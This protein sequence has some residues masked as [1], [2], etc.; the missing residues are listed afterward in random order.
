MVSVESRVRKIEKNP[1]P[2]RLKTNVVTTDKLAFRAVTTKT[3]AQ[4][5]ITPNEA[6][7]GTTV[8]TA[9]QPTTN[10]K[11]GTTWVNPDDGSTNVYSTATE[12]F[13]TVTDPAAVAI[14]QGKN[15]TYAQD[16]EPTGGTYS[17][18][19]LWIDTN[20]GN[21][22]YAYN[23][24]A[25]A[26]RQDGAIS[27][28]Q[29]TAN[30]KNTITY[31]TSDPGATPNTAGDIWWKYAADIIIGQWTGLGGTTWR[32][33][34]IG[35]ALVANLDAGK[36]TT[37]YLDVAGTV[38]I[39]TSSTASGLGGSAARI[40][41]NST[42]FYAYDGTV[43][44]VSITNTGTA[45]FSGTV[46][47]SGGS[48]TGYVTAG[49]TRIG[50]EVQAGKNGMYINTNNY[51]YDDATFKVGDGTESMS[52][53]SAGGLAVTGEINATSGA[54]S[55][56]V[57][58]GNM[59]IGS[60]VNSSYEGIYIG[61]NNYWYDD[62]TFKVGD[63][64]ESLVWNSSNGLT[65]TG[66]VNANSGVFSGSIT[67]I[68]T[69]TGGTI[70][71]ATIEAING[72]NTLAIYPSYN[73]STYGGGGVASVSSAAIVN[74]AVSGVFSG[75]KA[76]YVADTDA[77]GGI[78]SYSLNV[79]I[80][81][82]FASTGGG[83]QASI[84]SFSNLITTTIYGDQITLSSAYN[85]LFMNSSGVSLFDSTAVGNFGL[86]NVKGVSSSSGFTAATDTSGAVGDVVLVYTP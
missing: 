5:A 10:L 20:D 79:G 54:F 33:N 7:F 78:S 37:G 72:G 2:K 28:A 46:N 57:T 70:S 59:R 35:N 81:D 52:W 18:G 24:T 67:A 36:I 50:K 12:D 38:K 62:G 55:G 51:W 6:A 84:N 48:F 4:D 69:I 19:D 17:E 26:A 31:S 13:V 65:V 42:G 44:T 49:S 74:T 75:Y 1:S 76:V 9:T 83:M 66:T 68:G 63:G 53:T 16:D 60:N 34:S 86:R 30:G 77:T 47:A 11:E 8:V 64:S 32:Q 41:L 43:T 29:A 14:A 73:T 22:L 15:T 27:T 3:V 80:E 25:W 40:E 61:A 21:K 58:A 39:T 23:G 71:G 82:S 85:F 45:V 56:Y